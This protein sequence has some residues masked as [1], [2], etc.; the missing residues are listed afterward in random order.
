MRQL[1]SNSKK[2]SETRLKASLCFYARKAE[3][4]ASCQTDDRWIV[5]TGRAMHAFRLLE[6]HFLSRKKWLKQFFLVWW[7]KKAQERSS[8]SASCLAPM[9]LPNLWVKLNFRC[10]KITK[11][12]G[13]SRPNCGSQTLLKDP[14]ALLVKH[15]HTFTFGFF[16]STSEKAYRSHYPPLCLIKNQNCYLINRVVKCLTLVLCLGF[17]NERVES[18]LRPFFTRQ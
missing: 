17:A 14:K 11:V 9:H 13:C 7:L 8:N 10:W 3:G 12:S 6:L 15:T 2:A 1:Q 16:D 18:F 5:Q 4:N